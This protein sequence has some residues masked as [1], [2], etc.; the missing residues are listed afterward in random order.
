MGIIVLAIAALALVAGLE[1]NQRRN[2]RRLPAAP[3]RLSSAVAQDRDL[4]RLRAELLA[5]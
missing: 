2:R 1:S 3:T 4:E 5:R